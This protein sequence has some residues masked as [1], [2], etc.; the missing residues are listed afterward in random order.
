MFEKKWAVGD[1]SRTNS[2]EVE[3]KRETRSNLI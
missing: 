2:A 3:I 1:R